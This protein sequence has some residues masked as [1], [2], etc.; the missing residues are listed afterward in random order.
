MS[1]QE[2]AIADAKAAGRT[3]ALAEAAKTLAAAQLRSAAAEAGVKLGGMVD[4]IDVTRFIGADGEIDGDAIMAAVGEVKT[5]TSAV[6]QPTPGVQGQPVGGVP[7]LD[8]QIAAATQAGD[9][10]A[11]ISLNNQKLA[12]LVSKT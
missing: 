5:V 1:D 9:V 6:A 4:L 8:E 10:R 12:D 2:K 3:E 11:V 7:T